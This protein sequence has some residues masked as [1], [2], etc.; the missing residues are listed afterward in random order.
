[1]L[2]IWGKDKKDAIQT[3]CKSDGPSCLNHKRV[4]GIVIPIATLK[5]ELNL[6]EL[7]D[8]FLKSF[9]FCFIVR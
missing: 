7:S 2:I 1:M 4:T 5:R 3:A 9:W 8:L 6:A